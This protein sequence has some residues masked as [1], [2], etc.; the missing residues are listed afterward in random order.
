MAS[1]VAVLT[2]MHEGLELP[3]IPYYIPGTVQGP[4]KQKQLWVRGP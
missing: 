4:E 3:L 1:I 2:F